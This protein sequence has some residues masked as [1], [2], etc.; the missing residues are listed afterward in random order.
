MGKSTWAKALSICGLASALSLAAAAQARAQ[1]LAAPLGLTWGESPQAVERQMTQRGFAPIAGQVGALESFLDERR[2]TGE[3]LGMAAD[4]VAPLFFASQLFAVAVNFAPTSDR[5]AS[6][7]WESAVE[8][9]T[10]AYGRP[11]KRTKP[12]QLISW[13]AVLS[14]LPPEANRTVLMQLY[15]AAAKDPV[16][17]R[18]LLNDL[19]I[20]VGLWAPEAIWRFDNGAVVK[21][22]MR[23][24]GAGEY[25]LKALKPAVVYTKYEQLK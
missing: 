22:V 13:N 1:G 15:N 5:L 4:H 24:G 25:G 3:V 18:A 14:L 21:A 16:L 10:A 23:A 6:W 12:I 20:Q 11:V 9:L 8:K 7:I 19:Q 2:Y 17:G